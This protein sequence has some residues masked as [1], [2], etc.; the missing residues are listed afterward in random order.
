MVRNAR[1]LAKLFSKYARAA[2]TKIDTK[3][4]I[5]IMY[6]TKGVGESMT[7]KTLTIATTPILL[8]SA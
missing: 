4:K 6:R 7:P 3:D 8:R 5:E 1:L 2:P